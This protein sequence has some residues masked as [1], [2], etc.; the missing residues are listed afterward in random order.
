MDWQNFSPVLITVCVGGGIFLLVV[1]IIA[2]TVL[3]ML[4]IFGGIG[5]F[6]N[7]KSKEAKTLREA[8][9]NWASTIGKVVTSRVEVSGGDHTS[10]SPHIV[11]QYS[12][13]GRGYSGSQIKAGDVHLSSYSS[14]V[15]YDT[16]DKYPVGAEVTVYYDPENPQ[17]S[18]LER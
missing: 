9:R 2:A 18:A 14:R 16:V 15:A 13:Y 3:P 12:V 4:G 1:L 10:V 11:F 17:L 6:L 7:K 5:W 8:A